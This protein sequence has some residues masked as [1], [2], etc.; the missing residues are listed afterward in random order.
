MFSTSSTTVPT[1][2]AR[3]RS[4]VTV[5][6]RSGQASLIDPVYIFRHV[7]SSKPLIV[8]TTFLGIALAILLA[9]STPKLYTA[10]TQILVDPRD[11]K[12]VQNEVTPNGLPNEATLALIESQIAVVYSNNVLNRVIDAAGLE[13]DPEFNGTGETFFG[14]IFPNL[15]SFL[16][17][18]DAQSG[19]QRLVTVKNLRKAMTVTR[20]AK[21]FI[22]NL[23]VETRDP[24]KSAELSRLIG[25]TF[26]DQLGR[27]QSQTARRASDALSARLAELRQTVAEAERAV[28]EYK[29]RNRLV[30]VGGRLVDDDYIL[31][32]NDQLAR[33][34][35]ELAAL[36]VRAEQMKN[37]GI[38]DVV[39]GSFPE[40]LTSEALTRLRNTYSELAQQAAVLSTTLGPRHPQRM[41][42]QE[43]LASARNAIRAELNRIVAAAQTDLARAERTDRDLSTQITALK[44]KQLETSES[45]VK[46]R[47]L[48]R[49]VEA[50]RAVYEAFLLRARET[51]EQ[52]TLNTAN[53]HVISEATPPLE[54]SSLPRRTMV[55]LGAILGFLVGIG[56]AVLRGAVRFF[57]E[58]RPLDR[59]ALDGARGPVGFE[60]AEYRERSPYSPGFYPSAGFYSA[61]PVG[62]SDARQ[63]G[64]NDVA[65]V[66]EVALADAV[67]IRPAVYAETGELRR[68]SDAAG[69]LNQDEP[70]SDQPAETSP[71]E[72]ERLASEED[73]DPQ[74]TGD[75]PDSPDAV[76]E[77][78]PVDS[79][80]QTREELRDSIRAIATESPEIGDQDNLAETDD[81]EV[82]RLQFDI[83][84]VK[85]HIAEI[86]ERRQV[87]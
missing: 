70:E 20:D 37:V 43:A 61:A 76:V 72:E 4:H 40:E 9:L 50:S 18:D 26:I 29:T 69:E 1:A 46:L 28:E 25:A 19:R 53:V 71:V 38:D 66:G 68:S 84:A 75:S 64:G 45:F 85:R 79:E 10:D 35:G 42:S 60:A 83:A 52:E 36:R 80:P 16:R 15:A 27:V 77:A 11:I 13:S 74:P 82:E 17:E 81:A 51:G 47:E 8:L 44:T 67:G 59:V 56:I 32:T 58:V 2:S 63:T 54:P 12:V 6:E 22:I 55:L 23:S 7:W 21:S 78:A 34:R 49:E 57:Q 87:H 14:S 5:V 73:A 31:R 3:S 39:K 48:E 41:A 30:G 62:M 65:A 24:E 86:R 33:T